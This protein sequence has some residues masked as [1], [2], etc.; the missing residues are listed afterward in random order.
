MRSA[1]ALRQVRPQVQVQVRAPAR[2]VYWRRCVPAQALWA[3]GQVMHLLQ[4]G[5]RYQVLVQG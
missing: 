1:L 2:S 4:T 5:V 3:V